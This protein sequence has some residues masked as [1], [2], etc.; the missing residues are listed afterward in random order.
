VTREAASPGFVVVHGNRLEDLRDIVVELLRADPPAPLVAELFL[1]QSNGMKHWLEQSLAADHA[2]GIC[3]ATRI[4]LPATFLWQAYRAVLGADAVPARLPLDKDAL[5]W[6]LLRLLPELAARD[7]SFAPLR[8]YL[9]ARV[10][11]ADESEQASRRALQLAQQVADVLDGYQQYRADWLEDWERG[12]DVLRRPG[13]LVVPVPK[14]QSWQPRLWRAL[15]ADL[16][17]RAQG[18]SR[19]A[20]QREFEVRM[21]GWPTDAVRPADIPP[22]IVV[23]GISA[24][25]IQWVRALAELG[26]FA[27]VLFVVQN[28]CRHYWGH[29][30]EGRE[31]LGARTR[32]RQ[33]H[34][35]GLPFS[36]L[37]T[38]AA[39]LHA[40]SH[41]LLASWGRQG[42]D[43]LH[44]LDEFD[45]APSRPA[46]LSRV[47]AFTSPLDPA[48][49]AASTR[50]QRLQAGILELE[51][52]PAHPEPCDDDSIEFVAAH[53]AQREVEVLHDRILGWLD[54]DDRLRPQDIMV[55]VPDVARFAP[56][57]QAVFGRFA[58]GHARHV[59]FSIADVSARQLPLVQAFEQL[60][61]LDESRLTVSD[62]LALFEVPAVRRRFRLSEAEIAQ[63][64][65]WVVEAGVRWG[66]DARHRARW[67]L[68]EHLRDAAQNTWR[69]A[70]DRLLLGCATGGEHVWGGVLPVPAA[71]GIAAQ[72]LGQLA[73][74][75]DAVDATLRELAGLRPPREWVVV[76]RSLIDRFFDPV[77]DADE[78]VLARLL[79]DLQGWAQLCRDADLDDPLPLAVVR[80]YWLAKMESTGLRQRFF[81]GGV[82]FATLMPMRSI[83][84]R[85]VCLLG[86]NEA[87]YPR[88]VVPR[89]FDLMTQ[90]WRAGD[91]SRREDDRYL[92]LEAV[93]SARERLYVS[94]AGRRATDNAE[95]PP[96]V[97]VAQLRDELAQRFEPKRP[98]VLQPLQPFSAQYFAHGSPFRTYDAEWFALHAGTSAAAP[99][100]APAAVVAVAAD[101]A[102][103]RGPLP[104]TLSL[105]DLER[106]LRQP[107]EVFWRN[108]LRVAIDAP[109]E[110]DAE[111]EPFELDEL[112]E[113]QAVRRLID[114][115]GRS[116]ANVSVE[117]L[118]LSGAMPLA[119]RGALVTERLLDKATRVIE[120]ATPWRDAH[121]RELDPVAIDLIVGGVAIRGAIAG[122]RDGAPV[123]LQLA[124]RAG[125][126]VEGSRGRSRPRHDALV[127]LWVRQVAAAAADVPVTTVLCGLDDELRID[128]PSRSEALAIL[129][130]W[131]EAW[132]AA[133]AAPLPIACRTA[134]AWLVAGDPDDDE[135][136][137]NAF[138]G[139]GARAPGDLA[140]SAYLRRS[141]DG[142][143]ERV[144]EGVRRWAGPLYGALVA[145]ARPVAAIDSAEA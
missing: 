118:R 111:D 85:V 134:C 137:R 88:R 2:L 104:D 14:S 8:R 72:S 100:A 74:W 32:H 116:D 56:H 115:W 47:D 76:L 101:G 63:L 49:R 29:V 62:W 135:A 144:A 126:V 64:H 83:P 31:L 3:A 107:V 25:P 91:R 140:R 73:V 19:A 102:G 92:F 114:A 79:A 81:G 59:P 77:D 37:P 89:D 80:D 45:Q 35:R 51:P 78:R 27:Q 124:L 39:A 75:L 40:E 26:R 21:Q 130:G 122:L 12:D 98:E 120:R 22:R 67:G 11:G 143:D 70:I 71:G 13:R 119:A 53:S 54:A 132:Q 123:R 18:A 16:G 65:D 105:D 4:E 97:V 34:K 5:T 109:A 86:M 60:L 28:P 112:E 68:D 50:L 87:D 128:P 131:I 55:M 82:Q 145:R 142:Y 43:Y 46:A 20:V 6:R 138:E 23:F 127:A 141:V 38:D 44:L 9:D 61:R 66:L 41:P 103:V 129:Q 48:G 52:A 15:L 30:V 57:V 7:A 58:T 106:L 108:R 95:M 90:D 94:W 17:P 139:T 121:P 133:W 42:R 24:L 69:F 84:F 113:Y 117:A 110:A 33:R 96:S 99:A 10:A 1:V 136:P 125:A 93:L 36:A